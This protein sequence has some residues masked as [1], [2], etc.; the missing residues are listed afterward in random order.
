MDRAVQERTKVLF[1]EHQQRIFKQTDRLFVG[2]MMFQ[3]IAGIVIALVISPKT[4]MGPASQTHAHVW[5]AIFLGGGIASFPVALGIFAPG[6]IMTRNVIAVAQMLFSALLIHLTGGRIETHFHVFGSL[7]FLAFYRDWRILIPATI[8]VAIDHMVRGIFWPQSVFGVLTAS[9]WRWV[10]HAAWVIFEDIFLIRSCRRS[11][12]EMRHI[13][14][15]TA[16]LEAHNQLVDVKVKE[17]TR[18]LF[19]S[20]EELASEITERKKLKNMMIQSEKMA[21]VGQLAAGVAHEINNPVGFISNNIEMLE[22]YTTDYT[23]ILR[24]VEN[25]QKSIEEEN[26]EKA[27]SIVKAMS[28]FEQEINLDYIIND[29]GKLLQYTQRGIERIQKIVMDLRTFAREDHG[30]IDFVKIEEV[31][32]SILSIVQN[33][34]KYKAELKKNYGDTPLV[35]CNTQR[36]GQVFINLLVNAIQAIEK[37]GAIEVK[38][39]K[40]DGHVCVDVRDTGKG[41]EPKNL[42]KIFDPFFTT[43]PVGQGTGLGL[44]VSY[45]IIKKHGGEI[46]VQSKI[47]EG[48]VF[49][50]QLPVNL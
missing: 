42:E 31:I 26:M 30:A 37:K 22:Q 27:K 8:V 44:S 21:A 49:T 5:A 9:P 47:G 34:L 38:T 2:L 17:R 16:Q 35:K 18:E 13:A 29:T 7:A 12:V 45:E 11:V 36:V 1:L 28:Q 48:T 25:L 10:E 40:E 6:R 14:E 50:V 33:E 39:Y 46:K 20:K 43:K 32:D 23:K 4:W 3:W 41:I 19:E 15:R 24:M